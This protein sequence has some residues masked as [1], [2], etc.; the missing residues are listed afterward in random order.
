M[1]SDYLCIVVFYFTTS[2]DGGTVLS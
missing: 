1:I 2:M